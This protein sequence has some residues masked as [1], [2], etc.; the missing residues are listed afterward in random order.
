MRCYWID[1]YCVRGGGGGG[2]GQKIT[3]CN[4]ERPRHLRLESFQ[5]ENVLAQ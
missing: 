5:K 1:Y 3:A 4:P 2:G